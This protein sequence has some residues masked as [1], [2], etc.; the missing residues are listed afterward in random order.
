MPLLGRR[1][2][3][4]DLEQNPLPLL[5]RRSGLV[6]LERSLLTAVSLSVAHF[7]VLGFEN[8]HPSECSR[9]PATAFAE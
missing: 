6:S 5:Q 8:Y 7:E 3:F 4:E 2:G 9:Q 1:F